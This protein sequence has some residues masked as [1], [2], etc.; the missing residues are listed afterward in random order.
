[1]ILLCPKILAR[2]LHHLDA[3]R[4]IQSQEDYAAELAFIKTYNQYEIPRWR[5]ALQ[6]WPSTRK[7]SRY[8]KLLA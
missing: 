8:A 5:N 3:F 4:A 2:D 6:I 1:M 7:L